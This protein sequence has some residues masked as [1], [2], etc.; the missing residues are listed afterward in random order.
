MLICTH[1]RALGCQCASPALSAPSSSACVSGLI[2]VVLYPPSR[3][4]LQ[5]IPRSLAAGNGPGVLL[6][7]RSLVHGAAGNRRLPTA[8]L[9]ILTGPLKLPP[10]LACESRH[11]ALEGPCPPGLAAPN[12]LSVGP[13][14]AA[15]CTARPRRLGPR[16]SKNSGQGETI[17]SSSI[18]HVY[19]PFPP[20]PSPKVLVVTGSISLHVEGSVVW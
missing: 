9:S 17:S 19:T 4:S 6:D 15:R 18:L 11:S 7:A 3:R 10:R 2:A 12:F 16:G 1:S 5:F 13:Q 8:R 14:H 20:L